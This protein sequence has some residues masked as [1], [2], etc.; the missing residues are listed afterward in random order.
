MF[1]NPINVADTLDLVAKAVPESEIESLYDDNLMLES[2]SVGEITRAYLSDGEASEVESVMFEAVTTTRNR[3]AKT[4]RAFLR[5]LNQSLSG[6]GLTAGSDGG[7]L[8]E[9]SQG[10]V[11]GAEIGKVRRVAGV[12]VMVALLPISDGQSV[13]ILFHSPT[14]N[15]SMIKQGDTLTAFKFMLNKKDVTHVVAPI[16]GRDVSLRQTCMALSNLIEKNSEKFK[17]RQMLNNTIRAEIEKAKEDVEAKNTELQSFVDNADRLSNQLAV[18]EKKQKALDSEIEKQRK[19]NSQLEDL[20]ASMSS[21]SANSSGNSVADTRL[22]LGDDFTDKAVL[23]D[24]SVIEATVDGIQL[25]TKNGDV[26]VSKVSRVRNP[27]EYKELQEKAYTKLINAHNSNSLDSLADTNE[28]PSENE[29]KQGIQLPQGIDS[30]IAFIS[31]HTR[32]EA[33]IVKKWIE[34][35]QMA[36]LDVTNFIKDEDITLEQKKA[37][38]SENLQYPNINVN[39]ADLVSNWVSYI[40]KDVDL[41]GLKPSEIKQA[42]DILL[43]KEVDQAKKKSERVNSVISMADGSDF[44]KLPPNYE[45]ARS[46]S[47]FVNYALGSN[48]DKAAMKKAIGASRARTRAQTLLSRYKKANQLLVDNGEQPL[49]SGLSEQS[50]DDGSKE[51]RHGDYQYVIYENKF[52]KSTVPDGYISHIP[53]DKAAYQHE[54]T[55]GIVT[56]DNPP[57]DVFLYSI[58]KIPNQSEYQT[59]VTD[60]AQAFNKYANEYVKKYESDKSGFIS[61]IEMN[62]FDQTKGFAL[63]SGN[64]LSKFADDIYQALKLLNVESEETEDKKIANFLNEMVN[65]VAPTMA[66]AKEKQIQVSEAIN[67]LINMNKLQEYEDLATQV[68]DNITVNLKRLG[69]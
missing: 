31:D 30:L 21:R 44:S 42:A 69:S 2:T 28:V 51:I 55:D 47:V 33:S 54:N 13:S 10:V 61:S 37:Y 57:N 41:S 11:G 65:Y 14:S 24:G 19:V 52:H 3:L 36:E 20:I 68:V 6:T 60:M 35:Y 40:Q 25:T 9:G 58:K 63:P 12:P 53:K 34:T 43:K 38:I 50:S 32:L 62:F 27:K 56:Y 18:V 39:V 23:S 8:S 29:I 16:R 66:A 22:K 49:F 1:N 26:Y 45:L 48:S 67:A 7:E 59:L 4:M 5:V 17:R 64:D 46:V 15:G